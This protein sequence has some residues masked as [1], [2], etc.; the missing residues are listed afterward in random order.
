MRDG[1]VEFSAE[2]FAAMRFTLEGRRVLV[3][4]D[5]FFVADEICRALGRLGAVIA[6]PSP[7]IADAMRLLDEQPVHLAILDINVRGERSFPLARLLAD[8]GVP[9]LF[10]TGYDEVALPHDQRDVPRWQKPFDADALARHLG[11]SLG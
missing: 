5:Q 7:T 9:V 11:R 8:R 1:P 6:G 10:A 2:H 4:E 3:V